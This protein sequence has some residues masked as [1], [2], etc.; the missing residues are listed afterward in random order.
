MSTALPNPF[1]PIATVYANLI[2][3]GKVLRA[4]RRSLNGADARNPTHTIHTS[5]VN[6][7]SAIH[8]TSP[9]PS[10]NSMRQIHPHHPFKIHSP[11]SKEKL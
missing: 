3:P 10:L 2:N 1:H 6:H 8:P 9:S 11:Q 4:V 7:H 5:L